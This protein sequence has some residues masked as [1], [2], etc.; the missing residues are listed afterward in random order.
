MRRIAVV[1]F[2][3]ALAQPAW[4]QFRNPYTGRMFNNP[5]SSYLDTVL[6]GRMNQRVLE[7]MILEKRAARGKEEAPRPAP[8]PAE[9]R[10]PISATDFTPGGPRIVPAMLASGATKAE[11]EGARAALEQ[12]LDAYEKEARKHN[13]AYALAFLLGLSAQ[14]VKG[15]EVPDEQA[16]QLARDLND[17]LA[18]APQFQRLPARVKQEL[19]ET[20]VIVGGMIAV[21]SSG[22]MEAQAKQLATQVLASLQGGQGSQDGK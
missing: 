21:L 12:L 18:E 14:V 17:V 11:R 1:V 10:R 13:V 5:M 20:S 8:A 4:A 22:G 19:Y 3:V 9:A 2:A 15:E 7:R 6:R 16:E